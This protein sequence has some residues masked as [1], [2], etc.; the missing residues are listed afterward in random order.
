M[1][2][3]L[4]EPTVA[5]GDDLATCGSPRC[6]LFGAMRRTGDQPS[7]LSD[8][9]LFLIAPHSKHFHLLMMV[10]PLPSGNYR[11]A[12]FLRAQP[13]ER[14]GPFSFQR[15]GASSS[16]ILKTEE[17]NFWNL[18]NLILPLV[19]S[20]TVTSAPSSTEQE[21]AGSVWPGR[22]PKASGAASLGGGAAGFQIYLSKL[23]AQQRYRR[24]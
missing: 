21:M 12:P 15:A 4:P 7:H 6:Q 24:Q 2:S 14:L 22:Y 8:R 18:A 16:L 5:L 17:S 10:A 23:F 3:C 1:R 11:P 20:K 19:G 13:R 9:A